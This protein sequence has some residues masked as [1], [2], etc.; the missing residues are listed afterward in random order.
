MEFPRD[1]FTRIC[2]VKNGYEDRERHIINE[3]GERGVPVNFY[4]DWDVPEITEE[5][6]QTFFV[7]DTISLN[8]VSVVLKHM[9]IWRDFLKTD[10]PFCLVFEDDVFL[11]S[12]FVSKLNKCIAELGDP[13]RRA[14]VYLGNGS[15]YYISW[16]QL[17]KGRHL[18]PAPHGRCAD[19]Y[20]ITRPVA[21]AR[22]NWFA[23]NKCNRP[24]DHQIDRIDKQADVDVLWFER[25][26]VEQGSENGAFVSA[27]PSNKWRPI[28]YKRLE[29]N[30]KKYTRRVKGH[31]A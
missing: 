10:L 17:S 3:F 14:A 18:Y 26:I 7:P 12:D 6:R 19:S 11:A 16:W 23:S 30:W 8:S 27:I 20:L 13:Q 29:W 25:P 4:L 28:W 21:E 9:G 15:N 22:L 2:H 24:I 31:H 1:V 5:I